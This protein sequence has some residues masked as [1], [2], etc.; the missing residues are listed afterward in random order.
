MSIQ[1]VKAIIGWTISVLLTTL[2]SCAAGQPDNLIPNPGVEVLEEGKPLDWRFDHEKTDG[3]GV[4]EQAH[5]GKYSVWAQ[6]KESSGAS[7]WSGQ[8]PVEPNTTYDVEV[9]VKVDRPAS[10]G[11]VYLGV[12]FDTH[13]AGYRTPVLTPGKWQTITNTVR[14]WPKSKTAR[15]RLMIAHNF[16]G[17]VWFD[18]LSFRKSKTDWMERFP[19]TDLSKL[20]LGKKHPCV[21]FSRTEIEELRKAIETEPWAKNCYQECLSNANGYLAQSPFKLPDLDFTKVGPGYGYMRGEAYH[22]KIMG[23]AY[24]LSQDRKYAQGVRERLLAYAEKFPKGNMCRG[25]YGYTTGYAL[26]DTATAYDLIYES[27][28]LTPEDHQ[29]IEA[30]LSE[31]F[32]GMS[33]YVL[34]INNRSAVCLGAMA[35]IAFC[36]QDREMIEWTINGPYGFN[37]HIQEGIGDD[38]LWIEGISYG[39]MGLGGGVSSGYLAVPEAAYHAGIDLYSHPRF[40]RLLSAPLEY[41]FPDF[42]LPANGHCSYSISLLGQ[43]EARRYLKPWARLRDPGYAWVISEGLQIENWLP[44]GGHSGDLFLM[45]GNAQADFSGG[46]A[47]KL[48][49]KLFPQIGHAMLRSGQD[50]NEICVFLDYGPFGDHGNPDKMS[51]CLYAH[52]SLLS[53]DGITGYWWPKTFMYEC[54]TIGHNTMLVDEKTQFPTGDR[55]LNAWL[56]APRIKIVDA[57]DDQANPG[58]KMRRTLALA[59]GYLLDLFAVASDQEHRYDWAYHNFGQLKVNAQL[60]PRAGTLGVRDGYQYITG[61]SRGDVAQTWAAEWDLNEMNLVW[62]SSFE[63]QTGPVWQVTGWRIPSSGWRPYVTVDSEVHRTG[64]QSLRIQVPEGNQEFVYLLAT[65]KLNR[66][67]GGKKYLL[68]GYVRISDPRAAEGEVGLWVG[69]QLICKLPAQEAAAASKDWVKISGVYQPRETNREL[70]R[71]GLRN[72]PGA[73]VWFDDVSVR[74]REQGANALRLTM[75]G[76]PGTE[77][78]ASE[79]EGLRPFHQPLIIVR[80][81]AKN[82]VFATVM[83]PYYGRPTVRAIRPMPSK[84][85]EGQAGVEVVTDDS[86]DRFAVSY[87]PGAKSFADLSLEGMVAATSFDAKSKAL[88]YLCLGE[89]TKVKDGGWSLETAQPAT[90]YLEHRE[91]SYLLQTW[92]EYKGPVTIKGPGVGRYTRVRELT[93]E[94]KPGKEIKTVPAAQGISFDMESGKAYWLGK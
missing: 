84:S 56:P 2:C 75:L 23:L 81:K 41:A 66:F 42:S 79:G 88:R 77:L 44:L 16:E 48:E 71:V 80:R 29:K 69:E 57:E 10:S 91:G 32:R 6:L 19:Q 36:L 89:G 49:T 65:Y 70:V 9:W 68:E 22:P 26:G 72:A 78:I 21:F 64:R 55:K 67:R 18:D 5:S 53:P 25:G 37:Y 14:S 13:F 28:V 8:F 58:V 35:A 45:G 87:S 52:D 40:K 83:E 85:P 51:I 11:C 73:T 86:L 47:P 62:N 43:Q 82:T 30:M 12:S 3:W 33:R 94:G 1:Q 34:G 63:L 46:Q 60:E 74:I 20:K 93:L 38:G 90:L 92:G 17:K 27:G 4:S 15:I 7:W 31:G 50:E 59:D 76:S 39:Y 61:V 24:Q 54:Q